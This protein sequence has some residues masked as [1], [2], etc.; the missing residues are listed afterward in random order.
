MQTAVLSMTREITLP[1]V[2]ATWKIRADD[3]MTVDD[4]VFVK[5]CCRNS[6]LSSLLGNKN[7]YLCL[8]RSQGYKALL[9][10]RN[11]ECARVAV[12]EKQDDGCNLFDDVKKKSPRRSRT[13]LEEARRHHRPITV[14][15]DVL[16]NGLQPVSMLRSTV[17]KDSIYIKFD[18]DS[19]STVLHILT[20]MGF[21]DNKKARNPDQ[22]P[23]GIARHRTGY[24]VQY[25]AKCGSK[26]RKLLHAVDEALAFH[27]NPL[28]DE[29]TEDGPV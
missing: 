15:V 29:E 24:I 9:E 4:E 8:T 2:P 12:E 16:A 6:S 21:D 28:A 25:T 26:K 27:A 13:E 3:T 7:G 17:A 22:M 1:G 5:L 19:I 11:R 20:T 18:E 14:N 10:L 23:K